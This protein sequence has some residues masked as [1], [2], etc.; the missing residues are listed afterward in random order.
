MKTT[1]IN[2]TIY[3]DPSTETLY[4]VVLDGTVPGTLYYLEYRGEWDENKSV[5][6]LPSGAIKI[7][8][9]TK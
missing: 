6:S 7:W 1:E 9:P 8:T 5:A 3:V 2:G 4:R